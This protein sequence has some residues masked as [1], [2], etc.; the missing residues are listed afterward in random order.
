MWTLERRKIRI[1]RPDSLADFF[2][3]DFRAGARAANA[4]GCVVRDVLRLAFEAYAHDGPI[5]HGRRILGDS[6]LVNI[7]GH[8]DDFAPV[9]RGGDANAFADGVGGRIPIFACEIFR[10]DGD[11]KASCK[12]P[13]T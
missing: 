13:S 1:H 11:G 4:E 10:N 8:A 9:V 6:I 7:C 5:D 3:K 12:C 2:Q